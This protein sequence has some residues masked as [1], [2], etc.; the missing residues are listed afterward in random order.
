MKNSRVVLITGAS[1]GIG[2]AAG[3][4]LQSRGYDVIGTSRN[5]KKHPNHPFPLV[6]MDVQDA[7]S[8]QMV[9]E[10]VF[11]QHG[12]LDVLINNAG[13]GM[14]APLEELE[15]EPIDRILNINLKGPIRVIQQ[16]LKIMHKQ[17]SGCIINIASLAGDNGLPF[18]S[19]YSASKAALIRLTESL[20]LELRHTPIQCT[21]LSPGSIQTPIA[22]GRFYAP[23]NE[24]SPY[25]KQYKNALL[26]MDA[27]VDKGLK[28]IRVAKKIE[29]I[30]HMKSPKPHYSVGPFL[31]VLSPLI[32]F[33]LP[34]RTY[35]N[36]LASF[37]NLK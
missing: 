22:S 29:K 1:T 30:I 34:Q 16:V 2:L 36:V 13:M 8:I 24:N 18:R 3:L 31:E 35:E 21:T 23:L 15:M 10:S 14:A 7:N 19:L 4:Y 33:F 11:T 12:R 28:P 20:R 32:K 17:Q 27:H 9:L 37:Y 26:D 5:P 25:Y 6:A